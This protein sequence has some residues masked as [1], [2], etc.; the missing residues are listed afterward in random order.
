MLIVLVLLVGLFI[1]SVHLVTST[2]P[3]LT[4]ALKLPKGAVYL[5]A[6]IGFGYMTLQTVARI[7]NIARA[8]DNELNHQSAEEAVELDKKEAE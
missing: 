1:G 7:V 8:S 5:C 6:P 4:S 2:W 3:F